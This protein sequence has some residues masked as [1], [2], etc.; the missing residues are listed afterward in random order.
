M[1]YIGGVIFT[2]VIYVGF[3]FYNYLIIPFFGKVQSHRIP[4]RAP[5]Q[6]SFELI[7]KLYINFSRLITA[8]FVWH[9]IQFSASTLVLDLDFD[10]VWYALKLMIVQLPMLFIVYD[11]F[12]TLFHWALHWE[13]LYPLVHKHHH[14]Q[15]SPF[16]GNSDAIN[17]HPVEYVVGEY[18]H[19]LAMFLL[20]KIWG[21]GQVHALLF[22]VFILIGGALASLNHTRVDLQVPYVFNVRA[23]DYHHRQPRCNYGQ[24][25]MLWDCVFGTFMPS[26]HR[27]TDAIAIARSKKFLLAATVETTPVAVPAVS[28]M[29]PTTEG[30]KVTSKAAAPSNKRSPSP[31]RR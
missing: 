5:P 7:D 6:D 28:H 15:L 24:Y 22:F 3:E 27:S 19:L 4:Y 31:K 12:Y 26:E 2:A 8:L 25:L 21:P 1:S 13:W 9:C 30:E 23:H 16:R 14:R 10:S 11:F 20:T 17:V 29:A 18:N